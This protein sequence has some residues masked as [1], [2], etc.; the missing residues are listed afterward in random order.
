MYGSYGAFKRL[1]LS[2]SS[3][4]E[5]KMSQ[6]EWMAAYGTSNNLQQPRHLLRRPTPSPPARLQRTQ[7]SQA[8]VSA[9]VTAA[10]A[11]RQA[12]T[13]GARRGRGAR[14]QRGEERREEEKGEVEEDEEEEGEADFLS[15]DDVD[16]DERPPQSGVERLARANRRLVELRKKHK[17]A[18][19]RKA[20]RAKTARTRTLKRSTSDVELP[21]PPTP[22]STAAPAASTANAADDV[23]LPTLG[24]AAVSDVRERTRLLLRE[25]LIKRDPDAPHPPP[26]STAQQKGKTS[27]KRKAEDEKAEDEEG[28]EEAHALLASDIELELFELHQSTASKAY[29]QHSRDLVYALVHNAELAPDLLHLRLLPAELVTLPKEKLASHAVASAR[30]QEK[31]EMTR[32]LVLGQAEGARSDEWMCEGCGGRA[33]ETFVLKEGRDLRKAEVW[34]GGGD[35][36]QSVILIR[37]LQCK[38]EWKKEI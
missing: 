31:K 21:A 22:S 3:H 12:N 28:E 20:K 37:C 14:A 9:M 25:A 16:E 8:A 4:V 6:T 2:T 7:S 29:R 36:V 34:G 32:D 35:D 17:T 33:T 5:P 19:E 15:D 18:L 11:M 10:R 30:A 13:A 26:S 24:G 27:K 23:A 1:G 38:R